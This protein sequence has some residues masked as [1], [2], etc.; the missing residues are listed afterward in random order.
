ML[1]AERMDGIIP[2][3]AVAMLATKSRSVPS[4]TNTNTG[5]P[6]FSWLTV[7]A[8]AMSPS[9]L[10]PGSKARMVLPKVLAT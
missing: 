3:T 5:L 6:S 9:A 8:G 4:S 2:G 7:R 10:E 1:M